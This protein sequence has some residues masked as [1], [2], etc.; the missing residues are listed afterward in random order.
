M[1]EHVVAQ[2]RARRRVATADLNGRLLA[3]VAV[4]RFHLDGEAALRVAAEV[5]AQAGQVGV[6]W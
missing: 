6:Y 2:T 4:V 5:A 1:E 3:G